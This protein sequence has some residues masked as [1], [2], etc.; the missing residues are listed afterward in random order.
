MDKTSWT[1]SIRA[2]GNSQ[3]PIFLNM[4]FPCLLSLSVFFLSLVYSVFSRL[5]PAFLVSF[6]L[7][8][9]KQ[10]RSRKKKETTK[11][12]VDFDNKFTEQLN[13]LTEMLNNNKNKE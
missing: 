13:S 4:S 7:F 6:V 3:Y 9:S 10:N 5:S 1:H 8:S 2:N 11:S 12:K